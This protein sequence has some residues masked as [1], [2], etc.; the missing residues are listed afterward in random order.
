[1]LRN[2]EPM[3]VFLNF[4]PVALE[5]ELRF[6]LADILNSLAVQN[7]L[8]FEILEVFHRERIELPS[9]PR[10]ADPRY[11]E[12]VPEP[13]AAAQGEEKADEEAAAVDAETKPHAE[14]AQARP[15]R[16]GPRQKAN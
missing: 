12:P 6:F 8:R 4:G 1:V 2:P 7:D 14:P 5:F 3:V 15:K 16:V 9:N 10:W 11:A 13:P